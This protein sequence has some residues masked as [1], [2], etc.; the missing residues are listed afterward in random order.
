MNKYYS[1]GFESLPNLTGYVISGDDIDGTISV[2]NII[3]VTIPGRTQEEKPRI[4][5]GFLAQNDDR[6]VGVLIGDDKK[7]HGGSVQ[8]KLT[9]IKNSINP[10]SS[11]SGKYKVSKKVSYASV[12]KISKV[13]T[14]Y[15]ISG[16]GITTPV[17]RIIDFKYGN[18]YLSQ[19]KDRII[20]LGKDKDGKQFP[21]TFS[22]KGNMLGGFNSI[23]VRDVKLDGKFILT[24]D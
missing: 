10:Q 18:A 4:I 14:G 19:Y 23:D 22:I 21:N 3:S 16:E 11:M 17:I 15:T 13:K 24:K 12:K 20:G 9:G 6:I 1:E 7:E 2:Q 5:Q 8:G